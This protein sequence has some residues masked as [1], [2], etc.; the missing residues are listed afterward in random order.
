MEY[1]TAFHIEVTKTEESMLQL[2]RGIYIIESQLSGEEQLEVTKALC[3]EDA[4]FEGGYDEVQAKRSCAFCGQAWDYLVSKY[5]LRW[6]NH[7]DE[8]KQLSEQFPEYYFLL[9]GRGEE[10]DDKWRTVYHNGK[11]ICHQT[12]SIYFDEVESFKD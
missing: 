6:Y 11:I 7:D 8:M 10:Y 12:V 4:Y 1:Y 3:S 2:M 9:N 5:T